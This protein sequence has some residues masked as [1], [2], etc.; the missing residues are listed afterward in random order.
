M[1][2]SGESGT[3][4]HVYKVYGLLIAGKG[5]SASQNMAASTCHLVSPKQPRLSML[6]YV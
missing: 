6:N 1:S 3:R 4:D 2:T 5:S